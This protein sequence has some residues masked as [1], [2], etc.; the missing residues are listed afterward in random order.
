MAGPV[1]R[2]SGGRPFRRC[3][4]QSIQEVTC[5][6]NR[7]LRGVRR[8]SV[9]R[10]ATFAATC[11]V[12]WISM[13][14]VPPTGRPRRVSPLPSSCGSCFA[15]SAARARRGRSRPLRNRLLC[16]PDLRSALDPRPVPPPD[17][18]CHPARFDLPTPPDCV[19]RACACACWAGRPSAWQ[20][21]PPGLSKGDPWAVD[22]MLGGGST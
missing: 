4:S 14:P 17:S 20:E 12:P 8:A 11:C 15:K 18:I 2:R 7:A 9:V 3:Q 19:S 13:S 22:N 1:V 6:E 10:I 5:R 16:T 21:R